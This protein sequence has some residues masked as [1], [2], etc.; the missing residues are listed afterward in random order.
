MTLGVNSKDAVPVLR[1]SNLTKR[2]R[3]EK[4]SV[5][6]Y[7]SYFGIFLMK[8]FITI[9]FGFL[10][11]GR[12]KDT[13]SP[14]EDNPNYLL[15]K[16]ISN[17]DENVISDVE[18]YLRSKSKYKKKYQENLEHHGYEEPF[19]DDFDFTFVL[20]EALLLNN[21]AVV[22][23]W[24]EDPM[25]TLKL[26]NNMSNNNL[27]Q[28]NQFEVLKQRYQQSDLNITHFLEIDTSEPSILACSK[29]IGLKLIA[30]D[31]GTDSW[32]LVLINNK[33]TSVVSDYAKQSGVNLYLNKIDV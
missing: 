24:K 11:G 22:V 5:W 26:I 8:S 7:T 19:T 28:C 27:S 1:S 4:Y 32:V 12:A 6:C 20:V 14:L 29:N 30:I 23:D 2:A 25:V 10:L 15:A 13:H 33:N 21:K 9:F 16:H 17:N 31:N 18:L 3:E